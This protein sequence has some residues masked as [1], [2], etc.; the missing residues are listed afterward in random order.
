[1]Y[2]YQRFTCRIDFNIWIRTYP[3]WR[4]NGVPR[5]IYAYIWWWFLIIF[6][7]YCND[8]NVNKYMYRYVRPVVSA[9]EKSDLDQVV[10]RKRPRSRWGPPLSALIAGRALP[11]SPLPTPQEPAE[12]VL[13]SSPYSG[14]FFH[15]FSFYP[16]VHSYVYKHINLKNHHV[17]TYNK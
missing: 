13:A 16:N 5:R 12:T 2:G 7:T 10:S 17:R 9:I 1:M 11:F 15:F 14:C 4:A 8:L 3:W 6:C